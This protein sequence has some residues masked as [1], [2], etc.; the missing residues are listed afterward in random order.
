MS[1]CV[2]VCVCVMGLERVSECVCVCVEGGRLH[3]GPVSE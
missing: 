2:C 3:Q 1:E